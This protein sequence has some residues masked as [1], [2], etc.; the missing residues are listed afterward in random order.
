MLI[1]CVQYGSVNTS[2]NLGGTDGISQLQT[3]LSNSLNSIYKFYVCFYT[4][5]E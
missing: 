5:V 2:A 3:L 4:D 1:V